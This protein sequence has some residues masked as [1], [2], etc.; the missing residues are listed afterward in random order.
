MR[1]VLCDQC[2]QPKIMK[3]PFTRKGSPAHAA[4]FTLVEMLVVIAIIGVLTAMI[5]PSLPAILDSK[6]VER[7][8]A[9]ISGVLET[10]RAEAMA[11]RTYVHVAFANATNDQR[12]SEIRIGALAS[13]DGTTDVTPANLRAASKL[14][15]VDRAQITDFSDLSEGMKRAAQAVPAGSQMPDFTSNDDYAVASP[16]RNSARSP[17]IAFSSLA[18]FKNNFA[19]ISDENIYVI[20]ISPSGEVL[21]NPKADFFRRAIHFGI[22]ETRRDELIQKSQ[23]GAIVTYYGGSGRVGT[24]RP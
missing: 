21:G 2:N 13:M 19:G 1:S 10:S 24:L 16:F 5:T 9:E 6:S 20:T 18:G 23:N 4:G 11:K 7:A 12:N 17:K 8:A 14:I 15:K 3:N 22:A